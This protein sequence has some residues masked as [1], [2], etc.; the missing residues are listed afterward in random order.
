MHVI[1][2]DLC[3]EGKLYIPRETREHLLQ[4]EVIN[5]RQCMR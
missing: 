5:T 1:E 3:R 4:Q 2:D